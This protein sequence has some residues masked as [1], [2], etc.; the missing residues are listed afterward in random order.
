MFVKILGLM[1]RKCYL[2]AIFNIFLFLNLIS[3]QEN[4]V[5]T[6]PSMPPKIEVSA[7]ES[8]S[9]SSKRTIIEFDVNSNTPWSIES[10]QEWCTVTPSE[11]STSSLVA[12]VSVLLEENTNWGTRSANLKISGEKNEENKIIKIVQSGNDKFVVEPFT[13]EIPIEGG[14]AIFKIIANKVWTV[15]TNDDFLTIDKASGPGNENGDSEMFVVTFSANEGFS[16][17]GKISIRTETDFQEFTVHQ[18]GHYLNLVNME[19]SNMSFDGWAAEKTVL[20]ETDVEWDFSI[21]SEFQEWLAA[22]KIQNNGIKLKLK[23]N[24]LFVPRKGSVTLT[25]KD[26]MPGAKDIKIDLIQNSIL[27]TFPNGAQPDNNG[28]V[29]MTS[30]NVG[31]TVIQAKYRYKKCHLTF[32]FVEVNLSSDSQFLFNMDGDRNDGYATFYNYRMGCKG[33]FTTR[34]IVYP[35][36]KWEGNE[37]AVNLTKE[38]LD[39]VKK[40]EIIIDD[41]PNEIN[42]LCYKLL[43]NGDEKACMSGGVNPFTYMPDKFSEGYGMYLQLPVL[44]DGDYL[45][46]KSIDYEPYEK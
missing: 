32:E 10:D 26:I 3:C 40:I 16:R 20:L 17:E 11:S 39:A 8:Y 5:D 46:I 22:E 2:S 37:C 12:T 23:N 33:S 19:D 9:A 28:Y 4:Y 38:E 44:K 31:G 21:D 27:Y 30:E 24:S 36:G 35:D 15:E 34:N 14:D 29:K 45:I 1:K 41:D 18:K 42:K 7:D 6:Q 43:I 25:T 13:G